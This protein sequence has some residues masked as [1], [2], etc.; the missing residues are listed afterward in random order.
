L[1]GKSHVK[2]GERS[3]FIQCRPSPHHPTNPPTMS[4][5]LP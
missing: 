1:R 4:L 5:A 2:E 3:A